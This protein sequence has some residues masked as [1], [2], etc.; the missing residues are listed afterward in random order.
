MRVRTNSEGRITVIYKANNNPDGD[1]TEVRSDLLPTDGVAYLKSEA[2]PP[3]SGYDVED[4]N[5]GIV[6]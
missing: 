1:W 3:N 2:T 6:K 4:G 5:V